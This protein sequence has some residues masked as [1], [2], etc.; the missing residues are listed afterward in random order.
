[1]SARLSPPVWACGSDVTLWAIWY[2]SLI[3]AALST[4]VMMALVANRVVRSGRERTLEGQRSAISAALLGYLD[5]SVGAEEVL[6]RVGGRA[7]LL[8]DIVSRMGELVRGEEAS[9]LIAL[10]RATGGFAYAKAQL[11][12]RNAHARVRAVRQI[13]LYGDGAV[14]ALTSCLSDPS[15]SVRVATAMELASMGAGPDIA[16]LAVALGVGGVERLEELRQVFR[17]AI[18]ANPSEATA[19]LEDTRSSEALCLLLLDGLAQAGALET[20]SAVRAATRDASTAVRAEALRALAAFAHP[21][22]EADVL[23]ALSDPSWWVRA[24]A[25]NAARSIEIPDAVPRLESLLADEQWWV[26][27]RSAQAL[28]AL[29]EPGVATLRSASQGTDAAAQ[30]AQVVLAEGEVA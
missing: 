10:A 2:S 12:A 9:R 7:D 6:H 30:M 25:A 28:A 20:L 23:E 17:P 1:M 13:A 11:R 21:A 18:A 14:P 3:L 27:L 8:S 19:L 16:G 15:R 4:V 29:G 26:R 5:G 22:A 24:Q